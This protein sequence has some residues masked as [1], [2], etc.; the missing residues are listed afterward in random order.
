[1]PIEKIVYPKIGIINEL[2]VLGRIMDDGD[3]RIY[4]A[5]EI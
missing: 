4:E 2:E 1:M 3:M 5:E